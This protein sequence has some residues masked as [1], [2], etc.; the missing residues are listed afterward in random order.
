[1]AVKLTNRLNG[2]SIEV[3]DKEAAKF[4]LERGYVESTPAKK[5][6]TKKSSSSKSSK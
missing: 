5:A 2:A 1:M 3:A 6:A 4:W